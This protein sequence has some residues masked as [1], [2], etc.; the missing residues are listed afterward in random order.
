[1]QL[2]CIQSKYLQYLQGCLL[3]AYVHKW[4]P[5]QGDVAGFDNP[6]LVVTL[7]FDLEFHLG[8]FISHI[9]ILA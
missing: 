9:Q 3:V 6:I 2:A 7:I 8:V 5:N 4:L 1:V